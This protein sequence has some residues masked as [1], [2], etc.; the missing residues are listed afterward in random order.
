MEKLYWRNSDSGLEDWV[1]SCYGMAGAYKSFQ[2]FYRQAREIFLDQVKVSNGIGKEVFVLGY[3]LGDEKMRAMALEDSRSG[4][5]SDML[6]HV[7]DAGIRDDRKEMEEVA[8]E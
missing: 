8:R 6:M 1:L 5:H 7:W 2:R 4:S 3:L